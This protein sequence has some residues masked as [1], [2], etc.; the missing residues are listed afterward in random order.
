MTKKIE[1][2]PLLHVRQDVGTGRPLVLLHGMFAD[3]TQWRVVANRLSRYYRVIVVDLLGH[4]LSPRP[5]K[6]KYTAAE[7]SESLRKTLEKLDA[8]EDTT[9]VGYSMGGSVA[10]Q[11]AAK[12][13]DVVQL[14]L[15]STP[16][17]LK[18]EEMVAGGY[19]NSIFYTKLSLWLFH[20][21]EKRLNHGTL[22]Y[23][24]VENES[25]MQWLHVLI[26]SYDN[27][28]DPDILRMNLKELITDYRF[29]ANLKKV[30]APITFYAGKRD[31]FVVQAQLRALK[32]MQPLMEIETL[33]L[34][35]NDHAVVQYLPTQITNFLK[36]YHN[37]ELNVKD[38]LGTGKPLVLLHGIESSA[39]YWS[40]IVTALASNRR[41]ITVDLLGFGK[42]PKPLNIAYSLDD[43]VEWLKRTLQSRGISSFDLAGHSLG[44]LVALSYVATYP[45]EVNELTLISPVFVDVSNTSKKFILKRLSF[46][47]YFSGT[48]YLVSSLSKMVGYKRIRKFIPTIRTITN[49]IK[50]QN[51]VLIA[52][53]AKANKI[54]LIYGDKDPFIDDD[55]LK[56]VVKALGKHE[57]TVI[58]GGSHNISL[59]KPS[60]FLAKFEPK[61]Q[62]STKVKRSNVQPSQFIRQ[63]LK[64]ASPILLLK[65][66]LYIGAGLLL[67]TQYKAETLVA[68]VAS[69]VI[70]QSIQFIRGS[71]S[72]KNE[73][74]SH[75]GYFMVGVF[76]GIIGFALTNH[77]N[78]TVKIAL[79][80]TCGYVLSNGLSRLLAGSFW[81]A[82]KPLRRSQ[83]VSGALLTLVSIAAFLG[84]SV[85][86]KVIVYTLAVAAIARG[87]MILSY[88]ASAFFVAYVRGYQ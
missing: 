50:A 87:V 51:T 80:A 86:V 53:R 43:Q 16:F 36:R 83:L 56:K 41:V 10:L 64:L 13:D 6:A 60:I 31:V 28:L 19:A 54:R 71:F 59:A 25:M 68:I 38:D 52:Q 2:V 48:S 58:E 37:Q 88:L 30:S 12:H 1:N 63:L 57:T 46:I 23:K 15:I 70:Y 79:Y 20:L 61:R 18:P 49:S 42:S 67:F 14:Y 81:T 24:M 55:Q 65:V 22:L 4:G 27:K 32:K 5:E 72:L 11:Y 78:L 17:Y 85:S 39:I 73:G 21:V 47:E 66:S 7:H 34:V 3:G 44:A 62:H 40:N 33:G 82:S 35:K 84:S 8:T 45:K 75:I 26:D 69:L 77:L 74:L 29:A 76:G 9:V